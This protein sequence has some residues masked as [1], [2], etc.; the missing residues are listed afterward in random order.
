[1]KSVTS[2]SSSGIIAGELGP[3]PVAE[4]I[5]DLEE[6][7]DDDLSRSVF[8]E[9]AFAFPLEAAVVESVLESSAVESLFKGSMSEEVSDESVLEGLVSGSMLGLEEFEGETEVRGDF[10]FIFEGD[11]DGPV[12][13]AEGITLVGTAGGGVFDLGFDG[14][15]VESA[16][17]VGVPRVVVD[18]VEGNT[19]EDGFF[20]LGFK[21]A[22]VESAFDAEENSVLLV[23]EVVEGV[24]DAG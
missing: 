24:T 11:L 19:K 2:F 10:G 20:D 15:L 5:L 17:S 22:L 16:S 18:V 21:G 3:S 8:E 7:M 23:V 4:V 12:F 14:T 6:R 9:P 13:N 1:M